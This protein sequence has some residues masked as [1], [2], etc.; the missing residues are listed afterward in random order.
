MPSGKGHIVVAAVAAAVLFGIFSEFIAKYPMFLMTLP[1]Y[2]IYTLL[3]DVDIP[4]ST[5]SGHARKFFVVGGL[6]AYVAYY[7]MPNFYV[8]LFGA[9]C[10]I[11]IVGMTF[12]THRRWFHSLEAG[13]FLAAPL[14][15]VGWTWATS[16]LIGYY[17]HL[18]ADGQLKPD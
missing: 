18:F 3:P 5:I 11:M 13:L 16:A 9:M 15:F 6:L 8:L 1:V 2:F 10:G 7:L 17:V 12:A 4:S 14:M